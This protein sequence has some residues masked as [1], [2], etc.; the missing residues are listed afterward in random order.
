M[1]TYLV[2]ASVEDALG[3]DLLGDLG[4]HIGVTELSSNEDAADLGL[5]RL[6]LVDLHLD[7]ALGNV[8]GLVV[9]LEKLFISLLAG[10]KTGKSN[11][12][13]VTGGSTTALGVK[14]EA[15]TV[16]GGVEVTTHLEARLEGGTVALGN[17]VLDGEKEGNTLATRKLDGGGGII[18][19]LLLGEDKLATVGGDGALNAIKGVGLTGHDLGVDELLLGL[20]GLAD[21]LLDGPGL[22]L[23]AH[24]SELL[25]GLG[26]DGVFAD[27]LRAAVGKTSSLN[28][29]VGE[30]VKLGLG[31]GLG[32]TGSDGKT[33]SGG[34]GGL[35]K[36]LLERHLEL[37]GAL[38]SLKK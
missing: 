25:S 38:L 8:E 32:G 23:D 34:N 10:L 13:V 30:L 12:H 36:V 21:L 37:S 2:N 9:L 4:S 28:L 7:A 22:G 18:D 19:T 27:D 35:S 29:K 26:G 6:D 33:E 5:L 14:E 3:E 16:G 17:E 11:G 31:D 15:G 20:A 24:L 1:H